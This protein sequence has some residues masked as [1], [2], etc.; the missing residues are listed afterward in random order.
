MKN[1]WT[2]EVLVSIIN[3]VLFWNGEGNDIMMKAGIFIDAENV[4]RTGGWGLRYR[5]LKSFVKAQGAL[6][7]R[8]NTYMALDKKREFSDPEYR[9]KKLFYRSNLRKLGYKLILKEVRR[10][11]D[12]DG[13]I[14]TK[15]NADLELAIDA[16]LQARNLDYVVLLSGDGDFVRL[17]TA[18]QNMG[19]RVDVIGLH[20]CSRALKEAADHFV[21]GFLI[22]DLI[23]AP[24]GRRRG[25]LTSVNEDKYFGWITAFR[26]LDMDDMDSEI[27]I[28]G[29]DLENGRFPNDRLSEF[30][31]QQT[32]I[33][34]DLI[35]DG[36]GRRAVDAIILTPDDTCLPKEKDGDYS[37]AN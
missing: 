19:C 36:R 30:R 11:R 14:I 26:S 12:I 24:E 28:H 15:A 2:T 21:S 16:V 37:N 31:E 13:T 7:V 5:V 33:E 6:I 10:F 27:F 23:P 32:I 8:A 1:R 18:I 17:V 22:P 20:F 4:M 29:N 9:R 34:F 3:I 35:E 25:I